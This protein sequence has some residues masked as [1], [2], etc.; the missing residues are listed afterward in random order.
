MD[1]QRLE[2]DR[3]YVKKEVCKLVDGFFNDLKKVNAKLIDR[4]ELIKRLEYKNTRLARAY[5]IKLGILIT[6]RRWEILCGKKKANSR[7]PPIKS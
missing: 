4:E 1:E 2:S 6:K 7:K 5:A 3:D